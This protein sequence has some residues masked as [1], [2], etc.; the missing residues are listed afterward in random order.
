MWKLDLPGVEEQVGSLRAEMEAAAALLE[1]LAAEAEID[2]RS[3]EVDARSA[4]VG[5]RSAE[6]EWARSYRSNYREAIGR[7]TRSAP[8]TPCTFPSVH[9]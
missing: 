2:A 3:A 8:P 9:C 1:A 7:P 4:E 5:A 6:V